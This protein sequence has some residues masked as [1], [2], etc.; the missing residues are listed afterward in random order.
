MIINFKN[1]WI[2]G[3]TPSF[4]RTPVFGLNLSIGPEFNGDHLGLFAD[5]GW[6]LPFTGR[7]DLLQNQ[8]FMQGIFLNIG[9]K[10]TF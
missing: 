10:T 6:S 5:L 2:V 3:P 4:S 1:G 9:L 8:P 7:A